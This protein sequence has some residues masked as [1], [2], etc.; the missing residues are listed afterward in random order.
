M[1]GF[2]YVQFLMGEESIRQMDFVVINKKPIQL[3]C[4]KIKE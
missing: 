1:S 2:F 3:L 4:N